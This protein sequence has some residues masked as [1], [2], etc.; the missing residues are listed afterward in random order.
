MIRRHASTLLNINRFAAT[1]V[2]KRI[3]MMMANMPAIA[4]AAVLI[5]GSGAS[6]SH[7]PRPIVR[8]KPM[9]R[10]L[11]FMPQRAQDA[12][13]VS[14]SCLLAAANA[15]AVI[16]LRR[17]KVV[18]GWRVR[19]CRQLP[20]CGSVPMAIERD[21]PNI[22]AI[23]LGSSWMLPLLRIKSGRKITAHARLQVRRHV[24]PQ[25]VAQQHIAGQAYLH[26]RCISAPQA[27]EAS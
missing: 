9:M 22:P 24:L 14:Q 16:S 5:A 17:K 25:R 7:A 10:C 27:R 19:S 11:A 23:Q 18:P 13:R 1:T 26:R 6:R 20:R 3:A 21:A 2:Q 12:G 15:R 8:T 4:V